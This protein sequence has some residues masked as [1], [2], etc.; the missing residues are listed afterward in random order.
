MKIQLA[1]DIS[2]P[3]DL[4]AII[5]ELRQC[6]QW[7]NQA[8]VKMQVT[9]NA[10]GAAPIMSPA[11]NWLVQ[12][13]AG[14]KPLDQKSLDELI[15]ELETFEAKSRRITITLAAPATKELKKELVAW[16]RK[17]IDPNV[18]VEIRFNSTILGGLVVQ[19][20]SH[21]YDWSFRRQILAA[22]SRFPE[23]LRRV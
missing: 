8:A 4:L 7:L 15:A 6:S 13:W 22:R 12:E 19:Y 20:G 5:L 1:D 14:G 18:L 2:S 9:K 11:V 23:V 21:I 17:A 10:A 3:Q 16:C